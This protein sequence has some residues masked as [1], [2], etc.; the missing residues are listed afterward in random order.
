MTIRGEPKRAQDGSCVMAKADVYRGRAEECRHKAEQAVATRDQKA[1]FKVAEQWLMMAQEA[2]TRLTIAPWK[3][4]GPTSI[5]SWASYP[6]ADRS[7][8]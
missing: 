6:F 3:R 5:N 1:W 2:E 7:L 4:P 8:R